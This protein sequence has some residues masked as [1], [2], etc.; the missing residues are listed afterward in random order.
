MVVVST[1]FSLKDHADEIRSSA[2][3]PYPPKY[4]VK[5]GTEAPVFLENKGNTFIEI[6]PEYV[7]SVLKTQEN[8]DPWI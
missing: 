3:L 8:T 4:V 6:P 7:E 2:D 1:A 5:K